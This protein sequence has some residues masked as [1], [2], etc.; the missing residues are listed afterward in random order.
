MQAASLLSDV[1]GFDEFRTGQA[2]IV[3]AVASGQNT[4]AIIPIV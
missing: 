1:F 3:E 4:L 2:E